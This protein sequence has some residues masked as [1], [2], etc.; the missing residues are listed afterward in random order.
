MDALR[1]WEVSTSGNLCDRC[2]RPGHSGKCIGASADPDLRADT[3]LEEVRALRHAE[4]EELERLV[5]RAR[6]GEDLAR[7]Q[8]RPSMIA[9]YLRER[10]RQIIRLRQRLAKRMA[11]L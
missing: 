1:K 10:D 9:E 5:D 2:H 6:H 3:K 11:I 7:R 8:P 4:R